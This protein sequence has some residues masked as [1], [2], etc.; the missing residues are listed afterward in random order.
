MSVNSRDLENRC[1]DPAAGASDD[2]AKWIGIK[3]VYTVR[4][5]EGEM[6]YFN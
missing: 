6:M 1:S 2:H 3:F 5:Y 4:L